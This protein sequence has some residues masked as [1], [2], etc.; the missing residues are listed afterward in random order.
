MLVVE[1]DV[2]FD[3]AAQV[4]AGLETIRRQHVRNP[5]IEALNHAV[6]LRVTRLGQAVFDAQCD[7]QSVDRCSTRTFGNRS[8]LTGQILRVQFRPIKFRQKFEEADI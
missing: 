3:G 1:P 2:A 5:A 8:V 4:F 7:A 6:G